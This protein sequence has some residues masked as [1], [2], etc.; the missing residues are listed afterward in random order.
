MYIKKVL[1]GG[2]AW[3]HLKSDR[4]EVLEQLQAALKGIT[5]N[6]ICNSALIRSIG[7]IRK[8]EIEKS[9]IANELLGSF[10]ETSK[11]HYYFITSESLE[12]LQID[13]LL[14]F[15]PERFNRRYFLPRICR[16]EINFDNRFYGLRFD[17]HIPVFIVLDKE[18][19]I[20]HF[21]DSYD[22]QSFYRFDYAEVDL[23]E[24]FGHSVPPFPFLVL[25]VGDELTEQPKIISIACSN[26]LGGT[27]VSYIEETFEFP[28][29]Y[30]QAGASVLSYFGDVLKQ[31]APDID[32]KV[33]LEQNGNEIVI[34]ITLPVE[35]R[36]LIDSIYS[37]FKKILARETTIDSLFNANSVNALRLIQ[38]LELAELEVKQTNRAF[39]MQGKTI[40][41]QEKVIDTLVRRI[42]SLEELFASSNKGHKEIINNCQSTIHA[43]VEKEE[44]LLTAQIH[45][46]EKTLDSLITS[47][48]SSSDIQLLLIDLKETL[49][50][51]TLSPKKAEE[52]ATLICKQSPS[53]SKSLIDL[54][55][56]SIYG[57]SGNLLF[58]ALQEAVKAIV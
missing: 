23:E 49:E 50:T 54:M 47:L 13:N 56:N 31:T 53:T 25:E 35:H 18:F 4:S 12:A 42:E 52:V 40:D 33:L 51:N 43:M 30:Y 20:E 34:T 16:R 46:N 6:D 48:E 24:V 29:A 32:T 27:S 39:L 38:K 55:E 2:S 22:L 36:K 9:I 8:K 5:L 10:S 21:K 14:F 58:T 44:R 15:T 28:D 41:R 57:A 11:W 45:Q 17:S 26:D 3:E 1:N 19:L 7:L 37:N